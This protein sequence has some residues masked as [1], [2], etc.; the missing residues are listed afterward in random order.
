MVRQN[1]GAKATREFTNAMA[2]ALTPKKKRKKKS[3]FSKIYKSL[4]K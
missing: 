3:S 2:K 4:T 1:P